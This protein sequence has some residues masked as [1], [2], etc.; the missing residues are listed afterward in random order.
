MTQFDLTI[1]SK[2]FQSKEFEIECRFHKFKCIYESNEHR[3]MICQLELKQMTIESQV[4]RLLMKT[5]I[6]QSVNQ[7]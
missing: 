1:M 3:Q 7:I 4:E 5:H 6:E 2:K